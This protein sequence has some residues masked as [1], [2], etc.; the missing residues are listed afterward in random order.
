MDAD[1]SGVAEDRVDPVRVLADR[2][3]QLQVDSGGPSVR[4]LV[5]LTAK[6]GSPYTRGTIQDK[7]AG[8]S[9]VSWEFVE[10]FVRACALHTGSTV[11]SDLR[12][13]RRWH[14]QMTRELAASRADRRRV[15]RA[16]ECPYRGLEAFTAE[17]AEW[18]RGR[19]AAVEQV[20][21][22]LDAHRSGTM[23]LG[24]SGAG[25]SSVLQAGV[26]PALA[27]GALPGSDRWI[28]V[29][30]RPGKDLL[31]EV[32]RAGLPGAGREPIGTAVADR[33][34]GEPTGARVLLVV[35]QFEELLTPAAP[36]GP[37]AAQLD[38]IDALTAAIGAAGLSVVL[39]MRDDFYPRLASRAPALLRALTP[40]L[41]NVPATLSTEDLREIIVR[42]AEA[43]GLGFQDGLPERIIGDVPASA[44]AAG[45][46]RRAPIT[47]LPLLELALHQL[48]Q[49][50]DKG[51]LTHAAYDR[52]GGIAG[53][54]T[55]WCDSA[56]EQLP[57]EQRTIAQRVLTALV[58]PAD[59][60]HQIPAVRQQVPLAALRRLAESVPA[61]DGD[62]PSPGVDEVLAVLT[63]HRIVTTHTAR[64]AGQHTDTLGVPVAELVHEAL[65]RDWAVLRDW[66]G[67]DHRFQDWL[68]RAEERHTRWVARRNPG[69]LL[70][71]GDLAEGTD[72]STRRRLPEHVVEL[73]SASRRYERAGVLRTR[74]VAVVLATLL[75]A[76]L[77]ATGL[78]LGQRQAAV[79]A[80]RVAQSR[81][82][83]A[84]STALM[85]GDADLASLLA[86]QA[87]RT[88]PTAEAI[89]G[90]YAA[91]DSPL[92]RRLETD[93][94]GSLA[95][96]RDRHTLA[97]AGKDGMV[98][99]WDVP[100]GRLRTVLAGHTGPISKVA[101][102]SDGRTLA[103]AGEDHTVRLW[104]ITGARPPVDL[105]GHTEAVTSVLFSPDG[106]TLASA[107]EDH[108]VRL[109]DTSG[110]RLRAILRGFVPAP[111]SVAISPDGTTI[112]TGG[113][114]GSVR[115]WDLPRGRLLH[116][117]AGHTGRVNAV[118]F[119]PDSSI[120][121]SA[122]DDRTVRLWTVPDGRYRG[123]LNGH[124]DQVRAVAFSPDG[125][126]LATGGNDHTARLWNLADRRPRTTLTGHFDDVNEIVF[127]P[128]GR[129]VMTTGNDG[130]PRLW[131][132][133][134]G[135]LRAT[136]SGGGT[137]AMAFSPDG[138]TI[139]TAGNR[140][141]RL[142]DATVGL[143][144]SEFTDGTDNMW[145]VAFAPDGRTLATAGGDR[146]IRLWEAATGRR[147]RTFDTG[148][149]VVTSIEF[150]RDGQTLAS[151][152]GSD[153][154]PRGTVQL[155]DPASATARAVLADAGNTVAFSPDG[156]ILASGYDTG[157]ILLRDSAEP[158]RQ[159]P[160]EGHTGAV[161]TLAFSP[162]G[163]TLASGGHDRTVRLW[164]VATRTERIVLRG[165]TDEVE[166]VAISPDGGTVA[167]GS[168]EG[169]RLW[170]ATSGR[171][172]ATLTGHAQRV[173]TV[174]FSPD[175]RSLATASA[176]NTV[177]LWD[178]A[179]RRTRSIIGGYVDAVTTV[180]FSPDGRSLATAG[181]IGTVKVWDVALPTIAAAIDKIC[182]TVDRDLTPQERSVHLPPNQPP[183]PVCP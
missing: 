25:K 122:G 51:Q 31:A 32:E 169:V 29:V 153:S 64:T 101:F 137:A 146:T 108:T 98:R 85:A 45:A 11:P 1:R 110:R 47:V 99:L 106:S 161:F 112:A 120:L 129:A 55:T 116:T 103:S 50:R 61:A 79:T 100:D 37:E 93:S 168:L 139:A 6:V 143:P 86:V 71:G 164:D 179:S 163:R 3:R 91:A 17:Q 118:A 49:R 135:R 162:D 44:A 33:L 80:Q 59:D 68:R 4:D 57:A 70:H 23:V 13:W 65:I 114:H 96:S 131:N 102:S 165:H 166:A 97:T 156:R 147:I 60:D 21:A 175:G 126:I 138:R 123:T 5:R 2:L 171:L 94:Q 42:P 119:S 148:R 12:P 40:G 39:V 176:D 69:D 38:A 41:L 121:A 76:A 159:A 158:H 19:A 107:G 10:A 155:W 15:V 95:F 22:G 8:R 84:Q 43:A 27:R 92:R 141:A 130:A 182:R 113:D 24:P 36:D 56:I 128:D 66:A 115:L 109:W 145:I 174:A 142:W 30:V 124:T 133:T 183:G 157:A 117:L 167:S 81:Q 73:L 104:D 75:V 34:A 149:Q 144:R 105:E 46:A 172:L 74:I 125:S 136:F 20:I 181:W 160:L 28:A 127:S 63:G 52:V 134:D 35:D 177:R 88:S 154:T 82:L 26:L 140:G 18:F 83:A 170:D 58:R 87:Y 77:A 62:E 111:S 48:W 89:A 67:R 72:W 132:V 9:A 16:E 173:I 180:A 54:L 14:A 178:L 7:L 78:A 150:S 152:S 53:A 90:V 151:A